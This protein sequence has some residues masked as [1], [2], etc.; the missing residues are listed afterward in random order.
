[1]LV[2]F[3]NSKEPATLRIPLA[4]SG[5]AYGAKLKDWLGKAPPVTA[6]DSIEV[7]LP[8]LSAAIYR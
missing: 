7:H 2:I 4:G 6:A 1:M 5:I 8:A 3:N